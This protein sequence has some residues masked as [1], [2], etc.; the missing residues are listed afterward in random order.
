VVTIEV[1]DQRLPRSAREQALADDVGI[2]T[3]PIVELD[4]NDETCVPSSLG[5]WS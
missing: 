1:H 4:E 5:P 2:N 3:A